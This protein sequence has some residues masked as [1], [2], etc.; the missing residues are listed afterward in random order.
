MGK[1][2]KTVGIGILILL[3][4][5]PIF[6]WAFMQPLS[7]RFM[8]YATATRSL[9]QLTALVGTSLFALT[10]LLATRSKIIEEYTLGLDK[11]YIIHSL[12]GSLAFIML[13]FHPILLVLRFIPQNITQAAIWFLPGNNWAYN[14]GILSLAA[15][16]ILISLTFFI[17]V[18]YP[19]WKLS[20]K[21]LGVVFIMACFHFFFVA[22][23]ITRSTALRNYMIFISLIGILSYVYSSYLRPIFSK[24]FKYIVDEVVKDGPHTIV[25]LRAEKDKIKFKAGQF[26]YVK[27]YN[28]FFSSE[29]HPFS[30]ASS[31]DEDRIRFVIKNLGDYTS[32]MSSLKVGTK[33]EIEGPYGFFTEEDSGEEQ[34]WISGGIGLTPFLSMAESIKDNSHKIDFFYCTRNEGQAIFLDK[35]KEISSRYKSF[36]VHVLY[37]EKGQ[38]INL[39]EIKNRVSKIENKDFLLCGPPIMTDCL[40]E[41]LIKSGIAKNKIHNENFNL[42]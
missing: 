32:Q 23:D 21:F 26:A 30:I 28:F 18:K 39:E 31:P 25:Y 27:F 19:F 9:G 3:A 22:T 1:L 24:N 10:F 11:M 16:I 4:I 42:K 15:M 29:Q 6:I 2:K 40:I 36:K 34:L 14:F 8:D 20:H 17:K 5:I 41:E 13:L 37:S 33:A 12:A 38:R 7:S 35:F